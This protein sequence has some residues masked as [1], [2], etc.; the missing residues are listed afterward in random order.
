M[1]DGKYATHNP[2]TLPSVRFI[3]PKDNRSNLNS[4]SRASLAICVGTTTR[5]AAAPTTTTVMAQTTHLPTGTPNL[6]APTANG[7]SISTLHKIVEPLMTR[8]THGD[9]MPCIRVQKTRLVVSLQPLWVP[10]SM[11]PT[12]PMTVSRNLPLS[13][14]VG[15]IPTTPTLLHQK[16][17]TLRA[18]TP[19]HAT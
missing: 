11:R 9:Y 8:A 12:R 6:A 18:T 14:M 19:W 2:F 13:S 16:Q 17:N 7:S 15:T 5:Q 4:L 1:K 3:I 10:F